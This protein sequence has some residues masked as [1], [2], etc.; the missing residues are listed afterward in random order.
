MTEE[1]LQLLEGSS[2]KFQAV[3]S[4]KSASDIGGASEIKLGHSLSQEHEVDLLYNKASPSPDVEQTK[5]EAV[6]NVC[7]EQ[8]FISSKVFIE[9]DARFLANKIDMRSSNNVMPKHE[10]WVPSSILGSNMRSSNFFIAYQAHQV[11]KP[12]LSSLSSSLVFHVYPHLYIIP[13]NYNL[14][15]NGNEV[16]Q[17]KSIKEHSLDQIVSGPIWSATRFTMINAIASCDAWANDQRAKVERSFVDNMIKCLEVFD[18]FNGQNALAYW[19]SGQF[20]L[21]KVSFQA[22]PCGQGVLEAREV[23]RTPI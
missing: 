20:P 18:V 16:V 4:T 7:N 22:T 1:E 5:L 19:I 8:F 10:V 17:H 14:E 6:S 13:F 11:P 12:N 3:E 15:C 9:S 23:S 2:D 21:I